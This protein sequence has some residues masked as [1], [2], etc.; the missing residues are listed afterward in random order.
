MTYDIQ[1]LGYSVGNSLRMNPSSWAVQNPAVLNPDVWKKE[2]TGSKILPSSYR[3]EQ[4]HALKRAEQIIGPF[5]GFDIL[6]VGCGSGR[7]ALA[8]APRNR[9]HAIDFCPD[10]LAILERKISLSKPPVH[11]SYGLWDA[12][13]PNAAFRAYFDIMLDAY[14]SCHIVDE[15]ILKVWRSNAYNYARP[16]GFLLTFGFT[17]DDG[18]Y[19][20]FEIVRSGEFWISKDKITGIEKRLDSAASI[21]ALFSNFSAVHSEVVTFDDIVLEKTYRREILLSIF[22]VIPN[23]V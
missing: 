12:L 18:Y 10:A 16:G 22:R 4:S 23:I 8:L 20:Q 13:I 19:S 2:Y 14:F 5:I 3:D 11:L 17:V 1:D 9:V 6:D 7:N 15:T 21:R